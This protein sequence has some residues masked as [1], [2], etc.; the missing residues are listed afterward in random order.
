[1]KTIHRLPACTKYKYI[2]VCE[3]RKNAE[4]NKKTE[5]YRWDRVTCKKCL[6]FKHKR[7]VWIDKELER[8]NGS[9]NTDPNME[10]N[11]PIHPELAPE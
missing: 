2:D 3:C 10:R 1:M 4:F 8:D 11:Q 7:N 5:S 6:R 9:Y